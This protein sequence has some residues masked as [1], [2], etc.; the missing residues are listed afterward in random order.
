MGGLLRGLRENCGVIR[1]WVRGR[2]RIARERE[3]RATS[4]VVLGA[5]KPGIVWLDKEGD[6]FRLITEVNGQ[7]GDIV[8]QLV[9][10][11]LPRSEQGDGGATNR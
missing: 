6:R 3:E 4:E 5:M 1:E 2:Y 11:D 7:P 10:A 8:E 9:R